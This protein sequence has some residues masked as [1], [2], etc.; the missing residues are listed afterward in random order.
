MEFIGVSIFSIMQ[1]KKEKKGAENLFE[2][3]KAKT[4]PPLRSRIDIQI[5]ELR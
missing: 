2:E 4:Y 1:K 3:I 5:Q